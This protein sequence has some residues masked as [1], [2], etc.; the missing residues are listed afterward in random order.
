MHIWLW[1][2]DTDTFIKFK[3]EIKNKKIC[4]FEDCFNHIVIDEAH[5]LKSTYAEIHVVILSMI[6]KIIWF[7][8]TISYLNKI[9][10]FEEYLHLMWFEKW[11]KNL[12]QSDVSFKENKV[13]NVNNVNDVKSV[14]KVLD[15]DVI[16]NQYADVII[17]LNL[18]SIH[19]L[20]LQWFYFLLYKEDIS[21][22]DT[23]KI[24]LIMT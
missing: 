6:Y 19:L 9:S 21:I 3:D 20:N 8:T 2:C 15:S 22:C 7:L 17:D 14:L 13:D 10:N 16:R 18:F 12:S 24:V 4:K 23:W 5:N 1:A 11:V